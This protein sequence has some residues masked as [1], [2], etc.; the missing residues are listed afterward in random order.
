[1]VATIEGLVEEDELVVVLDDDELL[2]L[3]AELD[4]EAEVEVD[5]EDAVELVELGELVELVELGELVELVELVE[6]GVLVELAELVKLGV[7]VELLAGSG[8]VLAT[9]VVV[10]EEPDAV[11]VVQVTGS[12]AATASERPV[13]VA[14]C[15]AVG[16]TG[17]ATRVVVPGRVTVHVVSADAVGRA[18][19]DIATSSAPASASTLTTLWR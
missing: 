18:A 13:A 19:T 5:G 16:L 2:D 17:T 14:I 6:L 3:L 9:V 1:V 8:V 12:V 15:A 4:V 11:S 10:V 7:V